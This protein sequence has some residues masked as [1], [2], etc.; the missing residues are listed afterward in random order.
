MNDRFNSFTTSVWSEFSFQLLINKTQKKT[1]RNK[2]WHNVCKINYPHMICAQY[3]IISYRELEVGFSHFICDSTFQDC[4]V[5][6]TRV[7]IA[8]CA[9]FFMPRLKMYFLYYK[10]HLFI[11]PIPLIIHC[12]SSHRI[13][14]WNFILRFVLNILSRLIYNISCDFFSVYCLKKLTNFKTNFIYSRFLL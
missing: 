1:L 6:V 4:N 7:T 13:I 11:P 9:I 10:Y 8:T 12:W 14:I 5:I 3:L 2:N